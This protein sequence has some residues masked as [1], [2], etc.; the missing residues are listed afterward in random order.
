VPSV[1]E[2]TFAFVCLTGCMLFLKEISLSNSPKLP[3][4]NISID[5]IGFWSE[6]RSVCSLLMG[7]KL[8]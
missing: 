8:F 7:C 1:L 2:E 4:L 3:T 5:V 6:L